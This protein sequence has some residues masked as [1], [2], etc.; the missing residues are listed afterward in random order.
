[1]QLKMLKRIVGVAS[2]TS[3]A[4][5]YLELGVLPI[6]YEIEKRQIMF[7]YRILQLKPTDPVYN[8]F[9]EMV[10]LNEDG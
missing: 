8:L 5:I 4:F 6:D 3:N 10:K 7:L 9:C 2:S 1:M